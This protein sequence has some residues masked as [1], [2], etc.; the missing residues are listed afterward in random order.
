MEVADSARYELI[1]QPIESVLVPFSTAVDR[2]ILILSLMVLVLFA[3]AAVNS[4]LVVL[5]ARVDV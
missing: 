3:A 2:I 1:N 4:L 5:T